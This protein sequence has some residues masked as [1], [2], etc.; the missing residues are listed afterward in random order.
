M[1]VGAGSVVRDAHLPAYRMAGFNVQGITDLSLAKAR[2]LASDW[3]VPRAYR[4]LREMVMA[5]PSGAV[6]DL[7]L[8]ADQ[9]A[10]AL[11]QLPAGTPVL[12]QKPMGETMAQARRILA[13]CRRR[14]LLAAVNF[15]LRFAPFVTQ[16]KSLVDQGVIGELRDIEVRLTTE[17]PWGH[18]PFLRKVKRMEIPYH[19]IHYIDLMRHFLGDPRRVLALSL[20]HP[21]LP[22]PA[23]RTSI[24]MDY[25]DRVRANIQTNH[26][27]PFGPRHQESFI[28]WEGTKGAIKVRM[29]LLLNYPKGLPDAFEVCTFSRG[30]PA[31]KTLK[32]R[33]SW[34]P[35]A[36]IGSMQQVLTAADGRPGALVTPV[37]DAIR[38][39]ACAEAAFESSAR[40]G[41]SPRQ[42]LAPRASRAP[43]K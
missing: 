16:A 37:G 4:S 35:H 38:T 18:F 15:Q 11:G 29:G 5:A 32:V 7:A 39:M 14:R 31:W 30:R 26:F 22:M 27:H 36:F 12:I 2:R 33:G 28:K 10:G 19:S 23:S 20:R 21:E 17:T 41:V 25:G 42:F 9:A 24:I 6:F 13:T 43:R 1:I 8:P 40:G 3:G 34:F